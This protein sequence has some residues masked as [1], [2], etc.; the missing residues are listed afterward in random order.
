[1]EEDSSCHVFFLVWYTSSQGSAFNKCAC[2]CDALC[3]CGYKQ[4][5]LIPADKQ[6]SIKIFHVEVNV[7]LFATKR[8]D[9]KDATGH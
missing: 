3:D 6:P 8:V 9:P 1:M 7:I 5:I 2:S 4:V